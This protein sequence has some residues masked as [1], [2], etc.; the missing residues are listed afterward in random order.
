MPPQP[1]VLP[2]SKLPFGSRFADDGPVLL[3]ACWLTSAV[4]K[5]WPSAAWKA[6]PEM[7]HCSQKIRSADRAV[8]HPRFHALSSSIWQAGR[9]WYKLR[10]QRLRR[11]EA[12]AIGRD[13]Y[14]IK[15]WQGRLWQG[16]TAPIQQ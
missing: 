8:L 14:R 10:S 16:I 13:A 3:V 15:A 7:G 5:P 12:Q 2:V 1:E 9:P 6:T 4:S 11:L